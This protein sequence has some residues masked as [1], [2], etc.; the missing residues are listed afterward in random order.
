MMFD[1]RSKHN[2]LKLLPVKRFFSS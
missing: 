1:Q 2:S